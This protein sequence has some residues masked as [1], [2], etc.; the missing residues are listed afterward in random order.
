M[1]W[2]RTVALLTLACITTAQ[3]IPAG[4]A[5][6][7]PQ[8][9]AYGLDQSMS[10]LLTQLRRERKA[11]ETREREVEAQRRALDELARE[12]D[13]RLDSFEQTRVAL[14][15]RLDEIEERL[16]DQLAHLTKTYAAMPP[17]RASALLESLELD[18]ATAIL[19]KMR[20]KQSAAVMA[21]MNADTA[22]DLSRRLVKPFDLD[23]SVD[24]PPTGQR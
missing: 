11:L 5:A 23:G 3:L 1:T 18:L 15:L 16:G 19:R 20:H 24:L 14:E 7:E 2:I 13:K 10:Q 12:L 9:R 4:S 21:S 22:E 8:A 17:A 6:S